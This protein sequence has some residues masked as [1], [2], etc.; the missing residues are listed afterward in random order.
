M[1][2][3]YKFRPLDVQPDENSA[4]A[5]I[6]IRCNY[7]GEVARWNDAARAG[8]VADLNGKPFK[9]YY[10]AASRAMLEDKEILTR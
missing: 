10:N 4:S 8:W 2:N 9:A 6:S 1:N 5:T 7:S 3:P